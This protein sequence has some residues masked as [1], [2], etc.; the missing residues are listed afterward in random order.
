MSVLLP[1][2]DAGAALCD[3]LDS[4]GAQTLARHEVIAVD[5]GS[6]D[7]S[8]E[9]L[10]ARAARDPRL[11]VFRTPPRGIAAALNLALAEA[12]APFVARM[13]A[14]DSG[15][16]AAARGPARA[17]ARGSS[18][19]RPRLPCHDRCAGR[20]GHRRG[21]AGLR[22]LGERARG[23]RRHGP[24]A[25][26]RVADRPP[27]RDDAG[28]GA[29]RASGATATSPGPRTTTC[30]CARSTPACASRSCPRSCSSGAT[31]PAG[32]HART[33]A[34]R[35]TP[36]CASRSR[37]SRAGRSS[38]GRRSYGAPGRSG[39]PSRGRCGRRAARRGIRRG[40]PAQDRPTHPRRAGSR[41]RRGAARPRGAAPRCRRAG[42][43]A[44]ADRRGGTPPRARRGT[45]F[46]R[47]RVSA[48]VIRP[49]AC[50]PAA[51]RYNRETMRAPTSRARAL[52]LMLAAATGLVP[53]ASA[54]KK[55]APP[56]TPRIEKLARLVE[57]EDRRS[58]G[59][60]ELSLRLRDPDRG[61]RRRAALAAG[62]I[63]APELVPAAR[64]S[65]ERPG[66][67]GPPDGRLRARTR[68]QSAR[69]RSPARLAQGRGRPGARSRGR[70]ARPDRGRAGGAADRP[71]GRRRACPRRSIA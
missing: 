15:S 32:S 50:A 17:P 11:R 35:R 2:R 26:R 5:D 57:L 14:D 53:L 20:P 6:R 70:G 65:A 67:R 28:P 45:R 22:R 25:L 68:G 34:T 8:G 31:P 66:G 36:S 58:T 9:R 51:A 46:L 3:S 29:A 64:G 49:A 69:G 37:R 52:G 24:R 59:G 10:L 40:R 62:R 43:C 47:R 18:R 55:P 63:A 7:A 56:P 42:G 54:A 13:D 21:H 12:R 71:A 4:L 23:P 38:A 48:R 60:D 30:G 16:P 33:R 39:R 27:L 41:G 1:V 19:R 44:G 61:V